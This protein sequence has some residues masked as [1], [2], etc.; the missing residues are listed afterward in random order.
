MLRFP[1]KLFY[2]HLHIMHQEMQLVNPIV[3]IPV[4]EIPRHEIE[5]LLNGVQP[6]LR[7]VVHSRLIYAGEEALCRNIL[8]TGRCEKAPH[9]RCVFCTAA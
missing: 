8:Y 2:Q 6:I 3:Y 7:A 1:M 4:A 5:H 9:P